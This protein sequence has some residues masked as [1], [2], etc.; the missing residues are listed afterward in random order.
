M[1]TR[2]TTHP[3]L[4]DSH[5]LTHFP[6]PFLIPPGFPPNKE[7]WLHVCLR[8]SPGEIQP[9]A[10]ADDEGEWWLSSPVVILIKAGKRGSC[11]GPPSPRAGETGEGV[12]FRSDWGGGGLTTCLSQ[13]NLKVIHPLSLSLSQLY[14]W[15]A[16]PQIGPSRAI[17]SFLCQALGIDLW[18]MRRTPQLESSRNQE[19]G[20]CVLFR[21][22]RPPLKFG[23]K[24]ASYFPI[25][26]GR[27]GECHTNDQKCLF[28]FLAH[29][30]P[31]E[32][33]LWKP[34]WG[35]WTMVLLYHYICKHCIPNYI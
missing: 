34:V 1:V 8:S 18:S 30:S 3:L 26:D 28:H 6:S 14:A 17:K 29:L 16:K 19:Q 27:W 20:N 31:D 11:F 13:S 10:S 25:W 2:L 22:A 35:P 33:Y 15:A 21:W 12:S 5:S 23:F 4:S 7:G 9:T 32:I 24:S